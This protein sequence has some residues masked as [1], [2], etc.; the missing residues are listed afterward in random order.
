MIKHY[1]PRHELR[2]KAAK[3]ES[4]TSMASRWGDF[5]ADTKYTQIA[6]GF[7][8]YYSVLNGGSEEQLN[9]SDAMLIIHL[10]RFKW[11]QH[12]PHPP[13]TVLAQLMG[14]GIPAVRKIVRKLKRL[15]YLKVFPRYA[16][17]GSGGSVSNEYD[18]SGLFAALESAIKTEQPQIGTSV[19]RKR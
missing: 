16:S 9:S 15:N 6:N 11:D 5:L 14:I 19:E 10:M 8:D 17:D 3:A 2:K 12:N 18:L 13:F 1:R 4:S 7:L